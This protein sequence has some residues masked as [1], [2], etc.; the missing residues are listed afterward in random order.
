MTI[1]DPPV[2]PNVNLPGLRVGRHLTIQQRFE[3]WLATRDGQLV[4]G[5]VIARALLLR[6]RGWTHYSHKA[7]IESIRYDHNIRV[8]P[9]AGF[10]INDHYSSRIARRLM[11]EYPSLDGFFETRELRA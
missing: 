4:Y 5:E 7:I 11:T 9:E 1:W 10:K 2:P 3:E 8:G 6:E